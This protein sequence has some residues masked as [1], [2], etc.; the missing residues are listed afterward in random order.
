MRST[1]LYSVSLPEHYA[2]TISLN[3]HFRIFGARQLYVFK[4]I[5]LAYCNSYIQVF[6]VSSVWYK[7]KR[8]L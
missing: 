1:C 4:P 8:G 3:R 2:N 7:I 5:C 6:S